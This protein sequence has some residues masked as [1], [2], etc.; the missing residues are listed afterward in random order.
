DNSAFG[1]FGTYRI[2]VGYA[3]GT[4]TQ[5]HAALGTAFK[6]PTFE[7]NYSTTPFDIGNTGL[8]PERSL[9][10]EDGITETPLGPGLSLSATYFNQRF[11]NIID[12]PFAE[13]AVAGHPADSINYVNIAGGTADGVEL[14]LVAGPVAG[15]SFELSYTNLHTRVTDNGV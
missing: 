10:W 2:G 3:P 12:Y 15:T 5:F 1:T 11:R 6:E 7:Q 9:G 8:R 13:F 4:T 14:G